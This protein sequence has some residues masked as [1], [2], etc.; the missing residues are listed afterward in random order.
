MRIGFIHNIF[1]VLSQ[2]FI[3]KEMTGLA[4]RGLDIQIYSLFKPN[5]NDP[6]RKRSTNLFSVC[7][8]LSD[9]TLISAHIRALF[10][11]P[12]RYFSTWFY[13]C[14]SRENPSSFIKTLFKFLKNKD[15]NKTE[16][17]DMLLHFF[18][19]V[20]LAIKMHKDGVT[21]IN[22]H[23]ADAAASF[24]LL[25]ARLLNL[26]YGVTAHA[27]DIFTPQ[28]NLHEKISNAEFVLTCTKF[29]KTY[30]SE[31]FPEFDPDKFHVF[32]HGINTGRFKPCD[33]REKNNTMN[34]L[35][36][37]R[38]VHKKGFGILIGACQLLQNRDIPF[39]CHIIG[40]GPLHPELKRMI[41]N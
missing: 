40:D 25:C 7:Y 18:L 13:A 21:L 17:Q 2:T 16:R 9:L 32:Y 23:F 3:T 30:F 19:A 5:T 22:S 33:R 11:S 12:I 39:Q 6:A 37:G 24:A 1:P 35:S 31:R 27:Y 14:T 10:F 8:V 36:V 29:N 41:E 28:Y 26:P 34:L 4:E 15:M 38:L 20:P